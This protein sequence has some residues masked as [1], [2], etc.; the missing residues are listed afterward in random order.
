MVVNAGVIVTFPPESRSLMCL[1]TTAHN[2]CNGTVANYANPSKPVLLFVS[3][4]KHA[5]YTQGRGWKPEINA[6]AVCG[7]VV[8]GVSRG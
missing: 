5:F 6:P 3:P 8:W 7:Q 4:G 2:E 1:A